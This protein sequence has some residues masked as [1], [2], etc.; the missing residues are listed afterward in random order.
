MPKL[1]SPGVYLDETDPGERA[2]RARPM[3]DA[4]L[5]AL[6]TDLRRAMD[7]HAPDWT[8]TN[9][10]D[11][12]IT[13]LEVIAYLAEG[14][15][16]M[17]GTVSEARALAGRGADAL[18]ALANPR[19]PCGERVRRPLFFFGRLL[20]ADT[21][22]AEQDYHREKF[23]RHN[24]AVLGYGTV[25]GLEVRVDAGDSGATRIVVEPG[26]A[27]D[28]SGEEVCV[29]CAV[30]LPSPAQS[31]PVFVTLRFQ[32]HPCGVADA[33]SRTVEEACLIGFQSEVTVPSIALAR[34]VRSSGG[35]RVD[36]E[37]TGP[38]VPKGP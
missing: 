29:P 35:W 31:D 22:A 24:R 1:V 38:R 20:D 26:Y 12:G 13:L 9:E 23:R 7:A 14:L 6:A 33:V 8:D 32:E 15:A 21:L 27:I 25:S 10:S 37:F 11:P 5:A 36:P 19:T 16:G 30:T 4:A 18:A 2:R 34:L 3:E 17:S 28:R